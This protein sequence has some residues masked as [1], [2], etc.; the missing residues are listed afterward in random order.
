MKGG[1]GVEGDQKGQMDRERGDSLSSERAK[2]VESETE[3]EVNRK[4]D[5]ERSVE[6]QGAR[7]RKERARRKRAAKV[8]T[9]C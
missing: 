7:G 4:A 5:A 9:D 3:T 1:G 8:P 2:C 6:M